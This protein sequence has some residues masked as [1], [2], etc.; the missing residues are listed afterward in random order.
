MGF[1]GPA[2]LAF[3]TAVGAV[4]EGNESGYIG[5]ACG[6]DGHERCFGE[7]RKRGDDDIPPSSFHS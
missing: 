2:L 1:V 6:G 4:D 5:G 7:D 3:F